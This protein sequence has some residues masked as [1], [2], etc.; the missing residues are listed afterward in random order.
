[1]KPS[2]YVS[3]A[4]RGDRRFMGNY[5]A[6]IKYLDSN[7]NC[8][9]LAE[10]ALIGREIKLKDDQDIFQRDHRWLNEAD[11]L[12]AEVSAPSL[13]VGYEIAYAL[14]VRKIPVLALRH[15]SVKR[16][17]AMLEGNTSPLLELYAYD[18]L[19][20]LY[21]LVDEFLK[22]YFKIPPRQG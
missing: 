21:Q 8:T 19:E 2:I 10:L 15:L 7:E 13:G 22:T 18:T 9:A 5:K 20:E 1:M 4:I 14:N 16:T 17:S 11:G 3:G 12:V 6:L